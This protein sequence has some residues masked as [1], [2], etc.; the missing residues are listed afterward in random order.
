VG[1]AG[2][3]VPPRRR[4]LTTDLEDATSRSV[5]PGPLDRPLGWAR[6]AAGLDVVLGLEQLTAV[7]AHYLVTVEQNTLELIGCPTI[8]GS[9]ANAG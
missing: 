8:V 2:H 6:L 1:E 5:R 9:S 4:A 3:V 7:A